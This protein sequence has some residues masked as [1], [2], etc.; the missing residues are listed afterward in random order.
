MDKAEFAKLF[1]K[2]SAACV[3]F[4]RE[5]VTDLLP[6]ATR[7]ELFPN[8]SY[9]ENP[10]REDERVFPDDRLADDEFHEMDATQVVDFLWRDGMVPEW[11]DLSV[12]SADEQHTVAELRCCG[13]FTANSE[14]LYYRQ[15]NM[16]P[17][18]IKSPDLPVGYFGNPQRFSLSDVRR[19]SR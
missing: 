3:E 10:L 2:A 9:D 15:R 17:F 11:I 19:G 8:C 14:L 18:G 16:G 4:A 6:D 5:H 1:Q 7:Y 12:V 13:R